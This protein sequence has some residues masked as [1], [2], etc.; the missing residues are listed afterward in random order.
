MLTEGIMHDCIRR[1]L[2]SQDEESLEC[3]CRLLAT[4]GC[5]LDKDRSRVSAQISKNRLAAA[6]T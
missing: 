3:L 6:V 5:D 1:L 4:I 2:R